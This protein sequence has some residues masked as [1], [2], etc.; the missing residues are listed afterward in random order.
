MRQERTL[1]LDTLETMIELA[2]QEAR[3]RQ[4][5][6]SLCIS[7]DQKTC[8]AGWGKYCLVFENDENLAHPKPG[9]L[10]TAYSDIQ[11]GKLNFSPWGNSTNLLTLHPDGTTYNNGTFTYCPSNNNP[12]EAD[13]LIINN[14][15][16]A[17]RPTERNI[18]GVLLKSEGSANATPF[19][20]F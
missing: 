2:K 13:G 1:T 4:K 9:A 19:S 10:I 7:Q 5:K 8:F 3:H 12:E 6:I 20:C 17:Y 15:A 11:Y 16:R 14:A 18:F